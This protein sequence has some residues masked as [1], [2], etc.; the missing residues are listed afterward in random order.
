[1]AMALRNWRQRGYPGLQPVLNNFYRNR[2]GYTGALASSVGS[3]GLSKLYSK[4]PAYKTVKSIPSKGFARRTPSTFIK[5]KT[6]LKKKVSQMQKN[7]NSSMGTLI[8]RDRRVAKVLSVANSKNYGVMPGEPRCSQLELVLAQLR[9]FN[10]ATP[11]TLTQ[12][13]GST[14]T[15][16]REFNFK[17][18]ASNCVV[19]NN[20]QVPVKV[21]IMCCTVKH[22]TSINPA[23]AYEQGLSDV[24]NPSSTSN[25]TY[26]T[27]SKEFGNLWVISKS[28]TRTLSP[29]S[30]YKLTHSVKNVMYDPSLFD[31]HGLEY[32]KRFKNFSWVVKV[33]GVVGHDIAL[34]QQGSLPSGV[35][36]Q[37]NYTYNVYYDAGIDLKYI[38]VNDASTGFTN[39]G[40]V[41]SK[42]VSDNIGYSVS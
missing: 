22:D 31:S 30:S 34:D 29:G 5:G 37:L 3:Y 14:G 33:E 32:Q 24:G 18:I 42:P 26:F 8:Y 7:M 6:T 17:S 23:A 27:D 35:D 13:N 9:F 15:Y 36:V 12:G 25:L 1:M 40:V 10:P 21:T 39:G 2:Y 41:S 38:F 28:S 4:P 16:Y 11:G 19:R 20:Y